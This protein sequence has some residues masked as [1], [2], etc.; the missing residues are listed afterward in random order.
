ML[1]I[2]ST[3]VEQIKEA[4]ASDEELQKLRSQV[5]AG[6]RSDLLIHADGSL[7]FGARLCVPQGDVRQKLLAEAHHS[8]YTIHHGGTKMYRDLKHHFWWSGMKRGVE[9]FVSRCLICQ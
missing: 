7:R 4:Q 1:Q 6:L 3:L 9:K 8:Q 5:E 2:Q